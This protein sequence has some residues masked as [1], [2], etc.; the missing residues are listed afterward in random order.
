M[1]RRFESVEGYST[2]E[3]QGALLQAVIPMV[4]RENKHLNVV[5]VGTY[6]GRMTVMWLDEI[7]RHDSNFRYTCVD[8]FLGSS[9]HEQGVD[10]YMEFCRNTEQ[11]RMDVECGQNAV[12]RVWRERSVE[13]ADKIE[14]GTMDII[15]LDAAHDFDSV[16]A[17]ID[18]WW[19][20]VRVGGI[21]CG[22]DYI[23][24]WQGVVKAVN[25]NFA[26]EVNVVGRQQWWIV[27]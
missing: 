12:V 23:D 25:L 14:D 8:H 10:Y 3:D 22:D 20:K 2:W 21:L 5:E 1:S 24:G 19:P 4:L 18:A 15:Y 9:E 16:C 11:S 13:A 7:V 6:K 27:K 17:D 26:P